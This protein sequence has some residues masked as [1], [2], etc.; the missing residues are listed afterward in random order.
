VGAVYPDVGYALAAPNPAQALDAAMSFGLHIG[1]HWRRAS[2]VRRLV[3]T[4]QISATIKSRFTLGVALVLFHYAAWR[5]AVVLIHFDHNV[6]GFGANF[7]F[8]T[9]TLRWYVVASACLYSLLRRFAL[10]KHQWD[11]Y[12]PPLALVSAAAMH[13]EALKYAN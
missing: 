6:E 5:V 13:L 12:G 7:L 3:A 8:T 10:R 2:D 4:M 11:I 9:V 1:H